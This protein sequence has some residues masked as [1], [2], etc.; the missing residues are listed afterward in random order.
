MSDK[1]L[2]L[3]P[4]ETARIVKLLSESG[5]DR[6]A[7]TADEIHEQLESQHRPSFIWMSTDAVVEVVPLR[8]HDDRFGEFTG[9]DPE[10]LQVGEG[11][12]GFSVTDEQGRQVVF[13]GTLEQVAVFISALDHAMGHTKE[14]GD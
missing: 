11:E 13:S 3:R 6:D 12:V 10:I 9:G 5:L 2:R 8:A 4:R 14:A 7:A 1:M